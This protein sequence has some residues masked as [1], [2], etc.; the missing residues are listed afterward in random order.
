MEIP[1]PPSSSVAAVVLRFLF[2]S[3]TSESGMPILQARKMRVLLISFQD[4]DEDEE[5]SDGED[6]E[7]V[8]KI[9][10]YFHRCTQIYG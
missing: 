6:E 5:E 10:F 9:K 7:E 8:N 1:P 4:I 2:P 3:P